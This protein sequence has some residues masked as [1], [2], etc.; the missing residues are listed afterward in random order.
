[1]EESTTLPSSKN[2]Y[3]ISSACIPVEVFIIFV[4]HNGSEFTVVDI[5]K[6]FLS[7]HKI[8]IRY[9]TARRICNELT[10]AGKL[11]K[12]IKYNRYRQQTNYYTF[13]KFN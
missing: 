6:M 8:V 10:L 5:A 13:N 1:M 12:N 3:I 7:I 9:D 2:R 4:I 11:T